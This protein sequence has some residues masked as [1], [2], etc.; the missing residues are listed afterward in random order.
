M[1]REKERNIE[2]CF[3]EESQTFCTVLSLFK[4]K[5]KWLQHRRTESGSF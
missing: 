4:K 3:K 1:Q 2:G 5:D